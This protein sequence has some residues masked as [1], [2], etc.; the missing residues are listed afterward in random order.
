MTLFALDSGDRVAPSITCYF[1]TVAVNRTFYYSSVVHWLVPLKG[2]RQ[3]NSEYKPSYK[4][5]RILIRAK[6][7]K[8]CNF[9][10]IRVKVGWSDLLKSNQLSVH[11]ITC[12]IWDKYIDFDFPISL[13]TYFY[14]N[15]PF[16]EWSQLS[17][18]EVCSSVTA[19]FCCCVF[20]FKPLMFVSYSCRCYEHCWEV[21]MPCV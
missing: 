21:V 2:H 3:G 13:S 12:S 18:V 10:C 19:V 9:S 20:F 15:R 7:V 6:L 16:W 4:L 1:C 8:S 11:A 17:S 5:T 14:K